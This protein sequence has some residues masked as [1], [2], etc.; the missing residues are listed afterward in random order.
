[1]RSILQDFRFGLRV[2]IKNPIFTLVAIVTLALGIGANTAIFSVV[3]AVLL[4]PLPYPEAER[5]VFLWSTMPS[6]GGGIG[7]SAFPDYEGWRDRNQSFDE[8]AAF[9]YGDFNLSSTGSRPELIQGAHISSNLFQLLKVSP[10]LGRLF[11]KEEEQFGRHHVVLLSY[12]LWQRRF[13]GDRAIVGRDIKLGGESYVVAGVMPQGLPFFDN[14]P[15]VDLWTPMSF[16]PNDNQATRNN[17]F[18]NLVGRLKPGVTVAQAQQDTSA[19][20]KTMYGEN[21]GNAGVSALVVPVQEQLAGDSRTGLLVLLGAVAFVLLVACVNVANLL[22]ARASARQKE[23]GIRAS[24]GASRARI[25]RQVIIECLP[26]GIIG[27]LL[28]LLLAI[29]GIDLLSSLLPAS[30][31]RGNPI[32]VNSR[33]LLFTF[34]LALLTI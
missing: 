26:L 32:G 15:E 1:M 20:A 30:L 24:L 28:G 16:E 13:A 27:G 23:L 9:Y 31:P 4:R 17:Y 11:A 22:L 7:G 21:P 10:S 6:Q 12:G 14:L 8:L 18:I 34:A 29:W 19:I 5:L 33:V 3:D 2:L 25:M